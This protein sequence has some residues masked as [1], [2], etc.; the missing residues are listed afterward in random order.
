ML[1]ALYKR[2]TE[3]EKVRHESTTHNGIG[4]TKFDAKFLTSVAKNSQSYKNLSWKQAFAV[5]KALV[6]YRKQLLEIAIE[7]KTKD[8]KVAPVP[9]ELTVKKLVVAVDDDNIL[10]I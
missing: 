7:N 6:K 9:V 10:D 5:G 8:Q 2:Q 4:F 1:Q 3:N